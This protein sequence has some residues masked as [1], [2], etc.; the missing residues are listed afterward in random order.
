MLTLF[1]RLKK[2]GVVDVTNPV[3]QA[4]KEGRYGDIPVK[5]DKDSDDE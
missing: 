5:E 2:T 1:C 3:E 4:I